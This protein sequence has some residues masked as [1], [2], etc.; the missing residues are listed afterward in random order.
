MK[1]SLPTIVLIAC[2]AV[3]VFGVF[4]LFE[5]RFE[6]GDVY[7]PYSSLRADPLGTMALYESIEKL[8]GV[9]AQ[10]DFSADN[11]LPEDA[12]T[13]YLH[14]AASQF[15]W[16]WMPED[17]FREVDSF[18]RRGGRLVIALFPQSSDRY[19]RYHLDDN[20]DTNAEP[21]LKKDSKDSKDS[22]GSKD[23]QDTKEIK[24][25]KESDNADSK[26]TAAKKA[27]RK[28]ISDDET[29]EI[30]EVSLEEK[31]GLG[32]DVTN[33]P[34]GDTDAYES[35]EVQNRTTLPLPQWIEWHSGIILTNVDKA[36]R[37]IYSRGANPVVVERKFGRGTVV[38]A[39]DSYFVSNEAMLKDRHADF[40]AWLVGSSKT[41]VFDE[42]HLGTVVT[43]G[44]SGLMRKYR[45]YWFIAGL[46]VLAALFIWKNSLSLA[47]RYAEQK[48]EEYIAGKEAA[49]GFVNLLRRNI[50]VSKLLETCF[51][52]WKKSAA[53]SGK[54]S[55]VRVQ[56]AEAIFHAEKS[57]AENGPNALAAYQ[58]I[59]TALN[60]RTIEPGNPN[61]GNV[62]NS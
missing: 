11:H 38:V 47:P 18:V 30:P 33:L 40:L 14:L 52:E 17:T 22:K 51:A 60:N 43:S 48:Q 25:K 57:L 3:F 19:R 35:V 61:P 6:A 28:K 24:D 44:V 39:T 42:A 15:E 62:T 56:Q 23:D 29:A 2:A 8:P 50:P 4:Q 12:N 58:H 9:T 26:K 31:W 13:T 1:K 36:W 37:A 20:S 21:K 53:N 16:E 54:Y 5:L 27:K 41:V 10:R 55:K 46:I 59:S 7:Q 32:F 45:L 34:A 49:S